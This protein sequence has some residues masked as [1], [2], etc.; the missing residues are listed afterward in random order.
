MEQNFRFKFITI[1][2]LS[3]LISF[4]Y[5]IFSF[6]LFWLISFTEVYFSLLY[7]TLLY[8]TLLYFTSV[9]FSV[10]YCTLLYFT[11][12]YFTLLYFTLFY[13]TLLPSVFYFISQNFTLLYDTFPTLLFSIGV[14]S[15]LL[16]LTFLFHSLFLGNSMTQINNYK[17]STVF[18]QLFTNEEI[19]VCVFFLFTSPIWFLAIF[20]IRIVQIFSGKF[21]VFTVIYSL[22]SNYFLV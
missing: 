7:F 15:T 17:A 11:S 21:V 14:Y 19:A 18:Q 5:S 12:L 13:F 4:F 9:Y 6:Y 20:S 22:A 8:F 16:H 2:F 3:T 10:L 1:N